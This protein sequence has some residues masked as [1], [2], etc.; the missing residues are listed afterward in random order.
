[1]GTLKR[2]IWSFFCIILVLKFASAAEPNQ[3]L[4]PNVFRNDPVVSYMMWWR[5]YKVVFDKQ[6]V[7]SIQ[8]KINLIE[9]EKAASIDLDFF[10]KE[11][12]SAFLFPVLASY[13]NKGTVILER[14]LK[15]YSH[16]VLLDDRWLLIVACLGRIP[17]PHAEKI[18]E[19]EYE[20]VLKEYDFSYLYRS[21]SREDIEIRRRSPG[22]DGRRAIM[23]A[24]LVCLASQQKLTATKIEEVASKYDKGAYF[25]WLQG[26]EW[27]YQLMPKE[28]VSETIECLLISCKDQELRLDDILSSTDRFKALWGFVGERK[29]IWPLMRNLVLQKSGRRKTVSDFLLKLYM[30]ILSRYAETEN[31]IYPLDIDVVN[32]FITS[33]IEN[34]R[35]LSVYCKILLCCKPTSEYPKWKEFLQNHAEQVPKN[36]ESAV[37]DFLRFIHSGFKAEEGRRGDTMIRSPGVYMRGFGA[38]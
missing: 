10:S 24:L 36:D 6:K 25:A 29:D 18:L 3:A 32:T 8:E 27:I 20:R 33:G 19:N 15:E 28:K 31:G 9:M 7:I 23:D 2:Y 22:N 35:N 1:M 5:P 12:Q 26:L 11:D 30:V 34:S 14:F 37:E 21:P 13:G 4:P 17:T 38:R 16:K